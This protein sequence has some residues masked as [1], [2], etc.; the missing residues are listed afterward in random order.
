MINY[1]Y[2]SQLT[3][4]LLILDYLTLKVKSQL[5]FTLFGRVGSISTP[6]ETYQF[7]FPYTGCFLLV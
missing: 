1:I 4:L 3:K 7:Y 6:S 2:S 5:K